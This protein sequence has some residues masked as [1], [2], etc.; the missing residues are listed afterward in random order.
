MRCVDI[1]RTVVKT[2]LPVIDFG[3]WGREIR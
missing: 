1:F 3:L 2:D